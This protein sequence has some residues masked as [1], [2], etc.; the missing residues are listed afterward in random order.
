M[1]S[2]GRIAALLGVALVLALPALANA[3]LPK[4]SKK[5][6]VPGKSIGGLG[7]GGSTASV[8][9]A[10]GPYPGGK[11]EQICTYGSPKGGSAGEVRLE[12][13]DSVHF[14]VFEVLIKTEVEFSGSKDVANCATPLVKYETSK[15]IHLCSKLGALKKAYP[16]LK[17]EGSSEYVLKGPGKKA[18]IFSLTED[19]KVFLISIVSH[20]S[21]D[22]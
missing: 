13:K 1:R 16:Q 7:L 8:E 5:S 3:S 20:L 17:K 2:N 14:K 9:K 21:E 4:T 10:W 18:T 12:T 11:C 19:N 22:E 15:K 6:I